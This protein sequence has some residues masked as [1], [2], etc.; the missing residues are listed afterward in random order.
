MTDAMR[1]TSN[2]SEE[3]TRQGGKRM[4]PQSTFGLSTDVVKVMSKTYSC[5]PFSGSS[6]SSSTPPADGPPETVSSQRSGGDDSGLGARVTSRQPRAPATPSSR[7]SA[8]MSPRQRKGV[9][10]PRRASRGLAVQGAAASPR[11]RH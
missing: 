11:G 1:E 7:T 4:F 3:G 10:S 6:L 9:A 2:Q 5:R 8:G